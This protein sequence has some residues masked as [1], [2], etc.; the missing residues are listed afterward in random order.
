M[1]TMMRG[2]ATAQAEHDP[3]QMSNKLDGI[4]AETERLDMMLRNLAIAHVEDK[5][6]SRPRGRSHSQST[7]E[8]S[9]SLQRASRVLK[10]LDEQPIFQPESFQDII[11]MEPCPA[12]QTLPPG[13]KQLPLT[14]VNPGAANPSCAGFGLGL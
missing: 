11:I 10:G 2:M 6:P 8:R 14:H 3:H 7:E 1:D 12:A 5:T 13:S 4:G 9:L